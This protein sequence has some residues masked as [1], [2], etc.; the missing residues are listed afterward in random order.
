MDQAVQRGPHQLLL[1]YFNTL[2]ALE[3][4]SQWLTYW[5]VALAESPA[6]IPILQAQRVLQAYYFLQV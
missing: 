3:V 6:S 5:Q 4:R 2:Q 1:L